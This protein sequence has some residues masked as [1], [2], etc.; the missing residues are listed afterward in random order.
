MRHR[1]LV[2]ALGYCCRAICKS[3]SIGVHACDAAHERDA[4]RARYSGDLVINVWADIYNRHS[5]LLS[6]YCFLWCD[7]WY[8]QADNQVLQDLSGSVY[9]SASQT[10]SS[11][12]VCSRTCQARGEVG[13]EPLI[14]M[15]L[16]PRS[17]TVDA[18]QVHRLRGCCLQ[19]AAL[20]RPVDMSKGV[21]AIRTEHVGVAGRQ[22][23]TDQPCSCWKTCTRCSGIENAARLNAASKPLRPSH[24]RIANATQDRADALAEII[25]RMPDSRG[26]VVNSL[27][28]LECLAPN[29][30]SIAARLDGMT[31]AGRKLNSLL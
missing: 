7:K 16:A 18:V 3:N 17:V 24:R 29:E 31:L 9:R 5:S 6:K 27:R 11:F 23:T 28:I 8:L 4:Y 15:P 19:Q 13:L 26:V 20:N 30:F 25:K 22:G 21:R 12:R 10:C 1:K 14:S 2:S